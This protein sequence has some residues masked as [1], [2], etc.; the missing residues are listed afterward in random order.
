MKYNFEIKS[1]HESASFSTNDRKKNWRYSKMWAR[2]IRGVLP[3]AASQSS[4]HR[5]ALEIIPGVSDIPTRRGKVVCIMR[6]DHG[7][8]LPTCKHKNRFSGKKTQFWR[9][10]LKTL[11]FS[12]RPPATFLKGVH[13]LLWGSLTSELGLVYF[14]SN[15][16]VSILPKELL[17]GVWLCRRIIVLLFGWIPKK[18]IL[19]LLTWLPGT[20]SF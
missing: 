7:N 16:A 4:A 14:R 10:C 3:G 8:I 5:A 18:G 6:L 19:S 15:S 9:V 11:P 13:K 12:G 1:N 17:C 2:G 20:E